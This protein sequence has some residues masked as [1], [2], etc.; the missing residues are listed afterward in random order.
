MRTRALAGLLLV[1][2]A[3]WAVPAA[4]ADVDNGSATNVQEGDNERSS[5]QSGE[6]GSGDAVVGQVVGVA[7]SGDAS[8]DATNDTE[9]SD[10]E[11]GDAQGTNSAATIVGLI[12]GGCGAAISVT[13]VCPA[14]DVSSLA[15]SNVQ[16]GDNTADVAQAANVASGDG[17][18]GQI[19]GLVSGGSADLVMAGT[20]IGND[21]ETGEAF[22]GNES[23]T[24]VTLF[25]S[26]GPCCSIPSFVTDG[27]TIDV[28]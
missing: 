28:S 25:S 1:L 10:A 17:V 27:G 19:V 16:E 7:S 8:V 9:D 5:D 6:A 18:A 3:L 13:D 14:A 20:S 4:R 12:T 15:G 11:T 22:F 23:A 21:V 24:V 26:G 2:A